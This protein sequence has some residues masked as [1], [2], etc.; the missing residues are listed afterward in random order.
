MGELQLTADH[1]VIIGRGRLIADT[2][3]AELAERFQRGILVRSPQAPELTGVLTAAGASVDPEPD[4]AITAHGLTPAAIGDLAA[5]HGIALHEV[6][7]RCASLEDAYLA[8][9][10]DSLDY[11]GRKQ[12]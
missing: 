11:A 12:S 8:L 9:T 7:P 4:D 10:A 1:L 3:V 6:T 2:S 5:R